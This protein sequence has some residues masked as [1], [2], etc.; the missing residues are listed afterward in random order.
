[1]SLAISLVCL[2]VFSCSL[3]FCFLCSPVCFCFVLVRCRVILSLPL[4]S[5]SCTIQVTSCEC[6][7]HAMFS[8][9]YS[10]LGQAFHA[11]AGGDIDLA[12]VLGE[13][14]DLLVWVPKK[15][16]AEY[17]DGQRPLELP[18]CLHRL[19]GSAIM[20]EVGPAVEPQ[21]SE[22]QAAI[23]GGSC[24][25]NIASAF[26]HQQS[27]VGGWKLQSKIFACFPIFSGQ[28]SA[29]HAPSKSSDGKSASYRMHAGQKAT[30]TELS[31]NTASH[32]W[33]D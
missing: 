33:E 7:A 18:P 32:G 14:V 5:A 12:T 24:G 31:A 22:D 16:D 30:R 29:P 9:A 17:A 6:T 11:G 15:A 4:S 27:Y 19:F 21:L 23:R 8:I 13:P 2:I 3:F 25:R 26:R 1:M 28:L 10:L 20:E